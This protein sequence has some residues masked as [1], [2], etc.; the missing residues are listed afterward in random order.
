MRFLRGDVPVVPDA[1]TARRWARD[2]LAD[3]AY[4][5]KSLLDRVVAW[6]MELVADLFRRGEGTGADPRVVGFVLVA[7]VVVVAL[8]A[9]WIAGPV[10]LSRRAAQE[11]IVFDAADVRTAAQMR[12]AAVAAAARGSWH[13]A[14][15]DR[16]RAIV[17]SL[18]ERAL[19]D[20]RAGRTAHEVAD[21]AGRALP[22]L[23]TELLAASADFDEVR[24]GD[25][26]GSPDQYERLVS[27]DEQ[28][29]A[30]RPGRERTRGDAATTSGWTLAGRP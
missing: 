6:V 7:V 18:E 13:D 27:L 19:L 26:T 11:R 3:P 5:E 24:Y 22:D 17:R 14:V 12:T 25:G 15:L 21:D 23:H 20:E 1:E 16:F 10:R 2:E 8:V 30:A 28:V 4:H 9:L 29:Q